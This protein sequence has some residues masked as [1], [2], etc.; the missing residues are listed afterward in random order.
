[1]ALV[2]SS[3][4]GDSEPGQRGGCRRF[5]CS[6][7]MAPV[8]ALCR[9]QQG[10]AG[11]RSW[12]DGPPQPANGSLTREILVDHPQGVGLVVQQVGSHGGMGLP[13]SSADAA[14]SSAPQ[15][16]T[17]QRITR[18]SASLS[19]ISGTGSITPV[20][21]VSST[22]GR[23]RSTKV[24]GLARRFGGRFRW[25]TD[26]ARGIAFLRGTGSR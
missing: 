21:A 9:R 19:G 13:G 1:M 8:R 11:G 3:G 10:F 18:G 15:W 20:V 4:R 7:G 12:P 24:V 14:P 17:P 22:S 2:L 25:A 23:S 26:F 5:S 16:G 6:C